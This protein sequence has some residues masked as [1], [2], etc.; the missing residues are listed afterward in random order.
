MVP[1][2]RQVN[3]AAMASFTDSKILLWLNNGPKESDLRMSKTRSD[4]SKDN[5]PRG[6]LYGVF[7]VQ[8]EP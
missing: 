5:Y 6:A 2:L 7:C 3:T 8:A 4:R 1:V